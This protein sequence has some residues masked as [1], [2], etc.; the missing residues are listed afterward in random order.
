MD[1]ISMNITLLQAAY[2]E[3]LF[4]M[5]EGAGPEAEIYWYRPE[6]RAVLLPVSFHV[7]KR[8]ARLIRQRPFEI[9]WNDDFAEVMR[10]CG[11]RRDDGDW[12]N[13]VMVEAYTA[14]HKAAGA[15]CLSVFKDDVRVGGVY[16]VQRGGVFMAESMF[17]RVP[18]ASSVALVILMAGLV[19]AGIELVDVQ[20]KNPHSAKF[21]IMMIPRAEYELELQR[22]KEKPVVLNADYFTFD[23]GISFT[24]SLSQ[25]S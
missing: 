2:D 16:G 15:F 4:P 19:R 21:N 7:P 11:E 22:L 5:A 18:N 3:G 25:T 24:Q 14:W 9:R 17:S 13:P 6:E 23:E 12:I 1:E 20:F 10:Q 8:L